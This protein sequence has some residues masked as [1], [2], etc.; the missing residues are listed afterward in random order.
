MSIWKIL[1]GLRAIRQKIRI[2][3]L[4]HML[5]TIFSSEKVLQEHKEICLAIN[6]KQSVKLKSSSIKF[7]N[8]FK[9]LA[10]TFKIYADF[11]YILKGVERN[12]KN[13]ITSYTE[14]YQDHVLC[15]FAYKVVCIDDK[16]AKQLF[17]YRGK[18]VVN[19]FIE[20]IFKEIKYCK[21]IIKKHFNK[22]LVMSAEDEIINEVINTG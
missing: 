12:D 6:G 1:T 20:V 2:K 5:L 14:K 16:L 11:E 13:N 10:M 4:S 8:Y 15:S 22:N 19:K 17:F 21:Q 18:N 9:Q 3:T 7:K